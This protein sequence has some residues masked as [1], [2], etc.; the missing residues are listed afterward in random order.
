VATGQ[1]HD[2]G[3]IYHS[4]GERNIVRAV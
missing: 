1:L 3:F 2:I 4:E